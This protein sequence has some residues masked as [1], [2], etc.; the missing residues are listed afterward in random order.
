MLIHEL[1]PLFGEMTTV[2]E[3]GPGLESVRPLLRTPD[4]VTHRGYDAEADKLDGDTVVVA[5]IGPNPEKQVDAEVLTPALRDLPVGGRAVL[6]L[7]WPTAEVPYHRLLDV[8]VDAGCQVLQIV[9]L[10]KIARHG[11]Y[12]AVL[13]ARVDRLAPLRTHLADNPIELHG[14]EP[15]LRG[16]LRLTG[17]YSFGDLLARPA[18]IRLADQQDRIT[19]QDK[20]IRELEKELKARIAAAEAPPAP[21][22]SRRQ[23]YLKKLRRT[24]PRVG[25]PKAA[26]KK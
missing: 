14:E 21:P 16:L 17:E 6:L 11:A 25:A 10:D 8:L 12:C 15:T 26:E 20:R 4:T 19:A 5:F 1:L 13:A 24:L 9:P 3:V 7:G 22:V 23:V 2:V 18:R